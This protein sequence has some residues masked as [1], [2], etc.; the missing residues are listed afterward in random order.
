MVA[1]RVFFAARVWSIGRY[2][3]T[4]ENFSHWT[5]GSPGVDRR[6]RASQRGRAEAGPGPAVHH[7][8][9]GGVQTWVAHGVSA[10]WAHA[11]DRK[12]RSRLARD[13][14]GREDAGRQRS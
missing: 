14:A 2:S 4:H 9:G 8:P 7:D 3:H 10:R 12:G 1:K 11:R 13:P 5:A 6:A